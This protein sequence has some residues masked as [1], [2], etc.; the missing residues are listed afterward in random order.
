MLYPFVRR[1]QRWWVKLQGSYCNESSRGAAP[2]SATQ[3]SEAAIKG[4]NC[5][6][7]VR[8]ALS[9]CEASLA[10]ASSL[11]NKP[12]EA[13]EALLVITPRDSENNRDREGGRP[14]EGG[15]LSYSRGVPRGD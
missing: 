4:V 1:L 12:A 11:I 14:E 9:K 13:A 7:F 5:V 15:G 8:D 6:A 10:K 2:I 3:S